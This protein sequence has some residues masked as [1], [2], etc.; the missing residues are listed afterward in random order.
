M[1]LR[2]GK[3][4]KDISS[5]IRTL[6]QEGFPQNQSVA[7]ALSKSGKSNKSSGGKL[8]GGGK[9]MPK[10]DGIHYPYD[11]AGKKAARKA[12]QAKG[13]EVEYKNEGGIIGSTQRRRA[14]QG[15]EV[16]R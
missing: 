7:I 10:V 16:V 9:N 14:R 3:S 12:A 13:V 4:N 11:E 5:N 1:P 2:Q 8:S 15:A 6:R